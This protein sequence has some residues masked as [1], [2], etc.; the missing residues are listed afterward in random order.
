EFRPS[1]QGPNA[2]QTAA[3]RYP[4]EPGRSPPGSAV[5]PP[6]GPPGCAPAAGRRARLR[7]PDECRSESFRLQAKP[8]VESIGEIR[9]RRDQRE[10]DDLLGIVVL[11]QLLARRWRIRL[12]R[13][14]AGISDGALFSGREAPVLL[15]VNRLDLF[16]GQSRLPAARLV[17][18]QAIGA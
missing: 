8:V 18:S 16:V 9:H 11:G 13:Q 17:R 6:P 3:A 1:D 7:P 12:A 15:R 2:P 5:R 4:C 10:L 14:L